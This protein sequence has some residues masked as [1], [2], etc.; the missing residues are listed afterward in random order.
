MVLLIVAVVMV[1]FG[2]HTTAL[3]TGYGCIVKII[4]QGSRIVRVIKF[5]SET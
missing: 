4:N 5:N 1:I 3:K 2:G